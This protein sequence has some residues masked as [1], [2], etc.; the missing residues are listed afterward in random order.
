MCGSRL[1]SE[2]VKGSSLSLER[3]NDIKRCDGLS[4]CVFGIG[5]GVADDV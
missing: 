4:L 3:V 2:A 5:D 1:R